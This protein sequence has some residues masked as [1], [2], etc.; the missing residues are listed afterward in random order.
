MARLENDAKAHS[1]EIENLKRLLQ[2]QDQQLR[3]QDKELDAISSELA[4]RENEVMD[5]KEKLEN[6][7]VSDGNPLQLVQG[8]N[9]F[10]KSYFGFK[11]LNFHS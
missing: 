4:D 3:E 6:Q 8:I 10:C 11:Y 5:L 1:S 7:D 9:C 2:Q